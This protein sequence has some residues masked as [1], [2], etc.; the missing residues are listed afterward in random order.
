MLPTLI[1]MAP[2][3]TDSRI[4]IDEALLRHCQLESNATLARERTVS[5]GACL[6]EDDAVFAE[7]LETKGRRNHELQRSASQFT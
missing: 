3:A 4:L 6:L 5:S 2:S 7:N 1:P